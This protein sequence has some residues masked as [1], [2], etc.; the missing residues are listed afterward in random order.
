MD[1]M[2]GNCESLDVARIWIFV[3][4]F[5]DIAITIVINDDVKRVTERCKRDKKRGGQVPCPPLFIRSII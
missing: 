4:Y 1:V 3:I 5:I 2:A